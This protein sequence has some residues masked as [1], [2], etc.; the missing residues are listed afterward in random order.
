MYGNAY[1]GPPAEEINGMKESMHAELQNYLLSGLG[2][3]GKFS[4]N[5]AFLNGKGTNLQKDRMID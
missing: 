1:W 2:L 3:P 5:P 4:S